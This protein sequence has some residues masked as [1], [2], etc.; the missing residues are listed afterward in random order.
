MDFVGFQGDQR[1]RR[2]RALMQGRA[3][4]QA[5]QKID[6]TAP[7]VVSAVFVA[8]A[9]TKSRGCGRPR[10]SFA[11]LCPGRPTPRVAFRSARSDT[12]GVLAKFQHFSERRAGASLSAHSARVCERYSARCIPHRRHRFILGSPA[13]AGQPLAAHQTTTT[14]SLA[15]NINN[16]AP[17]W[18]DPGGAGQIHE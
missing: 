12:T 15:G 9:R 14:P 11:K 17:Q 7:F 2:M 6:L 1:V 3:V 8:R 16:H 10:M 13:F 18:H 5:F 4:A